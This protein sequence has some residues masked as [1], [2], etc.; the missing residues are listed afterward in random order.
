MD[1]LLGILKDFGP[2]V[3]VV[4]F[5]LWRSVKTEDHSKRREEAMGKAL[6]LQNRQ[7]MGLTE[8]IATIAEQNTEAYRSLVRVLRDRPCI[9][10]D[11]PNGQSAYSRQKSD[12]DIRAAVRPRPSLPETD[13]LPKTA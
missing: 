7:L 3:A 2:W 8:R 9:T 12:P 11:E 5:L 1:V 10:V 13:R 4:A 6:D